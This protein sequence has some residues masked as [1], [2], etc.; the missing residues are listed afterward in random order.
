MADIFLPRDIFFHLVLLVE[1]VVSHGSPKSPMWLRTFN[2]Q[3]PWMG[4]FSYLWWFQLCGICIL[5]LKHWIPCFS[6][7]RRGTASPPV[8]LGKQWNLNSSTEIK[9]SHIFWKDE[10]GLLCLVSWFYSLGFMQL[11]IFSGTECISVCN[12]TITS[13]W[14]FILLSS[15]PISVNLRAA[16]YPLSPQCLMLM[17]DVLLQSQIRDDIGNDAGA[18]NNHS[19]QRSGSNDSCCHC[20]WQL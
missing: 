9:K 16:S 15:C 17:I 20:H 10:W 4:G 5:I 7:H 14:D 18:I 11:H 3:T 12:Y 13:T 6:V 2:N 19:A 1:S 8:I